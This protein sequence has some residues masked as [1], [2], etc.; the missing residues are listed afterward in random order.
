MIS[1]LEFRRRVPGRSAIAILW[2]DLG[3]GLVSA[4]LRLLYGFRVLGRRRIPR[5]GGL[6]VVA[7]HASFLDPMVVGCAL[8]DRQFS[9]MARESLFRFGPFG[10]LLRSF[11]CIP[12]SRE[13]GDAAAMRAGIAELKAGR[14]LA[15]FPEGTRSRDGS[16][17]TFRRGVLL[18]L[19]KVPVQVVPMGVAGS[20]AIWPPQRS[21]PRWRG[22]LRVA[23]GEPI[24]PEALLDRD[25]EAALQLLR[26]AIEAAMVSAEAALPARTRRA[27]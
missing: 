26:E 19:R 24:P 20:H 4:W 15:I 14:C 23:V 9:P 2:F 25:P 6:I 22:A 13:G 12:L 16:L 8:R 5:A 1:M 27:G 21:R 7:N 3:R 17:Q 18:L 10:W 11:G